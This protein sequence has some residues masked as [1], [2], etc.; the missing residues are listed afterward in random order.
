MKNLLKASNNERLKSA[1]EQIALEKMITNFLIHRINEHI[2]VLN[3][4]FTI[5]DVNQAFLDEIKKPK[6]EIIG[7]H[8]HKVIH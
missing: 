8:S 6:E 1:E 2:V 3:T 5:A 4:D 7:S